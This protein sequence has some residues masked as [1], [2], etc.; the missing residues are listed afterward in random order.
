MATLEERIKKLEDR[1]E[2]QDLVAR[3][4]KATDDDDERAVADCFTQDAKFVATGFEGASGRD[5]I[6][7][8]LA[9]A[10]S[11]MRQTV[12]TPHY[13][14]IA[15]KGANEAD[16]VTVAHLEIG[17]G[18]TTVYA[19]VRY[20]DSFSRESDRWKIACREMR[21]VHAG[22]WDDVSRSLIDPANVRWPGAKPTTSDF[23][24]R[25]Q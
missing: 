24:R 18:D 16:G 6:M 1:A 8:F 12:H 5:A 15:F 22:S 10:R 17:M 7:A 23:P 3:Y 2:I 11:N 14:H 20:L 19:A 4:F 9:A 25:T 13:V 21:V